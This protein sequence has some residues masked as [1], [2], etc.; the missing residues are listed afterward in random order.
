MSEKDKTLLIVILAVAALCGCFMISC[1][2]ASFFI[3]SHADKNT[4]HEIFESGI[5]E[6]YT[7]DT[8]NDRLDENTPD[9]FSVDINN[10]DG[11]SESEQ[12]IIDET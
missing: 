7:V 6:N 4:F 11:L 1:C 3:V 10:S 9:T 5:V 8:Q 2:A 12:N